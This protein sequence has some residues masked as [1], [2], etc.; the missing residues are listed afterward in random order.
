MGRGLD[1][2]I[3]SLLG[4]FLDPAFAGCYSVVTNHKK[5][6]GLSTI[7][8]FQRKQDDAKAIVF[9]SLKRGVKIIR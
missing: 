4:D 5:I 9:Q 2:P 3:S 1:F 6:K 8:P 7:T